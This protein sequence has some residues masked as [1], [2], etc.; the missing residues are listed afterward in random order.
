VQVFEQQ[1]DFSS[2]FNYPYYSN[3]TG[4]KPIPQDTVGTIQNYKITE[5]FY[6]VL[7]SQYQNARDASIDPAFGGSL[8][9]AL[10]H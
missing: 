9:F 10:K 5:K 3:Q 8:N 1:K 6:I 4:G 7:L 2:H